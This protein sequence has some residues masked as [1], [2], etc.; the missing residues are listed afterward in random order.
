MIALIAAPSTS[1]YV[2]RLLFALIDFARKQ[3][4]SLQLC[5]LNRFVGDSYRLF[6]PYRIFGRC[7]VLGSFTTEW[8]SVRQLKLCAMRG[9]KS[10]KAAF[11]PFYHSQYVGSR[12]ENQTTPAGRNR[13]AQV[14]HL[15]HPPKRCH[16][17]TGQECVGCECAQHFRGS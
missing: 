16:R 17:G 8:Q 10:E 9:L 11:C 3:Q 4:L 6:G 7:I 13:K 5:A 14:V 1:T 2:R 15:D 12:C